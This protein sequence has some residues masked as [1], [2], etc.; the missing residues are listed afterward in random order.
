MATSR[1]ITLQDTELFSQHDETTQ[2][3]KVAYTMGAFSIV[4]LFIVGLVLST[5]HYFFS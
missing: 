2:S 3:D 4:L 1:H 5:L